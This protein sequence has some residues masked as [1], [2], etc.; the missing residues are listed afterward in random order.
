MS[1]IVLGGPIRG[2][3]SMAKLLAGTN[4]LRHMCTDPQRFCF[5]MMGTPDRLQYDEVSQWV[6][7]NWMPLPNVAIEGVHAARALQKY[8]QSPGGTPCSVKR[9]V[10]MIHELEQRLRPGQRAQAT[11]VANTLTE[12]MPAIS[13][14]LELWEPDGNG[15]FQ[16]VPRCQLMSHTPAPVQYK[17]KTRARA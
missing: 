15:G 6:A 3:T 7:E 16:E 5:N 9:V 13:G 11:K 8:L 12:L 2:K 17:K 14:M 10:Y 4:E 1:I